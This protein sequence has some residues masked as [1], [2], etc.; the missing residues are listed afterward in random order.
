[1]NDY[2]TELRKQL[3][4]DISQK[5]GTAVVWIRFFQDDVPEIIYTVT[6]AT[7]NIKNY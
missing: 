6:Q 4:T 5:K 3:I 7:L 1:M 2:E